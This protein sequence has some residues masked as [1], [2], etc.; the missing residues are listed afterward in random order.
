VSL[1]ASYMWLS[2]DTRRCFK[3]SRKCFRVPPV[4]KRAKDSMRSVGTSSNC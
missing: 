4:R 2:C 3:S 1:K